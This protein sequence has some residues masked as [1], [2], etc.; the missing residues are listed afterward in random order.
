MAYNTPPSSISHGVDLAPPPPLDFNRL[1]ENPILHLQ[2]SLLPLSS[3]GPHDRPGR[4][5][6]LHDIPQRGRGVRIRRITHWH[7]RSEAAQHRSAEHH[8]CSMRT[9]EHDGHV[10]HVRQEAHERRVLRLRSG[11]IQCA[12][13]VPGVIEF[14]DD[15]SGLERDG[16]EGERIFAREVL[17]RRVLERVV[18]GNEESPTVVRG[19]L[20]R[21]RP[22]MDPRMRGSAM[23]DRLPLAI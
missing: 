15:V 12:D 2:Q 9:G 22:T 10:A 7:R 5:H 19:E 11:E 23:G 18:S 17:Q 1:Q 8:R 6:L 14:V 21:V 16:F 13:G 20:T 3:S 4:R